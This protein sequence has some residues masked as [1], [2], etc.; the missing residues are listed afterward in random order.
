MTRQTGLHL[1]WIEAGLAA[2]KLDVLLH[3]AT[4][5]KYGMDRTGFRTSRAYRKW[6]E[7]QTSQGRQVCTQYG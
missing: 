2:P 3:M 4:T 1:A 5:R 6:L 7:E